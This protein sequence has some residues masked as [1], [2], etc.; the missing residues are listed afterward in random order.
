[1][2]GTDTAWETSDVQT[3]IVSQS[4]DSRTMLL[5][6]VTPAVEQVIETLREHNALLDVAMS[7]M[8]V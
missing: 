8:A 1:V 6:G 7:V 5:T 4:E 3:E 2:S